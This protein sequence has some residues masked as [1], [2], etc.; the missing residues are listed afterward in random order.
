MIMKYW[1]TTWVPRAIAG[2]ISEAEPREL[3]E[4]LPEAQVVD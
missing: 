2:L 3:R 1:L 4:L